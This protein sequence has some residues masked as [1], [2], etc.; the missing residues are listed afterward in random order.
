MNTYWLNKTEKNTPKKQG[1]QNSSNIVCW[2]SFPTE[3]ICTRHSLVCCITPHRSVKAKCRVFHCGRRIFTGILIQYYGENIGS[4]CFGRQGSR[5]HPFHTGSMT[6]GWH[7]VWHG[8]KLEQNTVVTGGASFS[9]RAKLVSP[10]FHPPK[11][12]FL[13]IT[14]KFSTKVRFYT[15][16]WLS[17]SNKLIASTRVNMNQRKRPHENMAWR[18]S[19]ALIV[20]TSFV[21]PDSHRLCAY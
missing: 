20:L 6:S 15:P 19:L 14:T 18:W 11:T 17:V 13:H 8:G 12:T 4:V 7:F 9:F 10:S 3:S 16:N 21:H 2:S 5:D 1:R